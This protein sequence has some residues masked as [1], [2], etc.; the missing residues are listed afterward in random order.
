MNKAIET[1]K[2]T[3]SYLF[4]HESKV[5]TVNRSIKN[6][7]RVKTAS[8]NFEVIATPGHTPGSVCLYE[9]KKKILISGDTLF[10]DV[11]I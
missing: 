3:M 4:G 10:N 1:G 7:S 6:G 8:F 11:R 9:R 5:I 2:D